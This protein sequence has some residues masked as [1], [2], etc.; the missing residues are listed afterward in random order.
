MSDEYPIANWA[1]ENFRDANKGKTLVMFHPVQIKHT[2]RSKMENRPVFIE[3][4][5]ITKIMAGDKLHVHDQPVKEKDKEEYPVEWTR[6][7]KTRQNRIPGTPIESWQSITDTQKAEFKAMNIFTVEQFANLADA[8]AEKIMGF[9]ALREKAKVFAVAQQDADFMNKVRQEMDAKL[10]AKDSEV[11]ELKAM[12][13]KLMADREAAPA[14]A[15]KRV[16]KPRKA[17]LPR[18]AAPATTVTPE[19]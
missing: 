1:D 7:E 2:Y 17:L 15:P 11:Q 10:Q 5:F 16:R 6:W 9:H 4:I 8:M 14:P 3:K 18:H 12:L 13:Q 19:G